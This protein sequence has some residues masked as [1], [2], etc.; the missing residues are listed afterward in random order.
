MYQSLEAQLHDL[1]WRAEPDAD[2]SPLLRGFL[3]QHPGKAL[4]VGCGS[5]RLLLPL[6]KSG[7][8]IEGIEISSEMVELLL[9]DAT[10]Q[11]LSPVVHHADINDFAATEQ[12]SAITIPAFTLQLLS[13]EEALAA[14]TSLRKMS[15]ASGALYFTVF[16]P[17]SEILGDLEEDVWHL[18]K[19]APYQDKLVAR[20]Y[21][22]HSINR[23]EQTLHRKHRY[24]I[25]KSSGKRLEEHLSEQLLQ[26]YFLAELQLLLE[27]SGWTYQ[28]HDADLSAGCQD[29]DAHILTIYASARPL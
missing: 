15:T 22:K 17:W 16:I 7:Y 24:E 19:K 27:K 5:G 10:A 4:E 1:F 3:E 28:S 26:W 20:C 18:D 2:E 12:Y 29:K 14:L 9:A 21:T 11:E 6:I 8:P 25:S 13:R 23:L